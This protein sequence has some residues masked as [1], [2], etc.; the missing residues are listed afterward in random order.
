[1]PSIVLSVLFPV[2]MTGLHCGYPPQEVQI[3][4]IELFPVSMTGL[5]CG[6]TVSVTNL[7]R[8]SSFP[9]FNDRAPLRPRCQ[10][11]TL[12]PVLA[13][14]PVSMTGLHCGR[15]RDSERRPPL[16]AFPG[17]NDR[18]PLRLLLRGQVD[19]DLTGPFPGFNDRAPL[20]Q[21]VLQCVV[22]L[23]C[24][25]FPVSMTGLHCGFVTRL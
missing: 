1:M 12:H 15:R 18:A 6:G 11:C 17:F 21:L 2:S 16:P 13:L 7:R 4:D 23:G 19:G 5:H 24:H 3:N 14:F 8:I 20:R 10:P 25:L 9:G 22:L